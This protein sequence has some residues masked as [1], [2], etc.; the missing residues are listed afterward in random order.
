MGAR[1]LRPLFGT[2][3][4]LLM[5]AARAT[6]HPA[7]FTYLDIRVEDR[8]LEISLIAHAF[9]VAHD[10]GLTLPEQL[11]QDA[12][13]NE[14]GAQFAL[15]L[16]ERI[17]LSV[18]GRPL[19]L[20]PWQVAEALPERQSIRLTTRV[21]VSSPPGVVTLEAHI[22]PY[23]TA[24]QTFVN[25]YDRGAISSQSIL[26]AFETATNYYAGT[27]AG[28]W[29]AVR[30]ALP[31]AFW[32]ILIGLEHIAIIVGLLLLGGSLRRT[33]TLALVFTVGHLLTS[34][35][36][37][38][39]IVSLPERLIDPALALAVV[40]LGA[41]NLMAAGGRDV[42]IWMALVIGGIHGFGFA[43]LL[44]FLGLSRPALVWSIGAVNLGVG[45]ASVLLALIVSVAIRA[46]QHRGPRFTRL[47][48]VVGSVL[49][50]TLGVAWFAQ[51][52]FFPAFTAFPI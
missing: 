36:A 24:H 47:A 6:A 52:V 23:D 13:L 49:V 17:R 34:A 29:A 15:L 41:D 19:T 28:G 9:D 30:L 11:M 25:F 3:L 12:I 44:R 51:R 16:P 40:Y 18:D 35:L 45:A 31:Q 8:A 20:A 27:T 7:P 5:C 38:A 48:I 43:A 50:M 37:A 39:S 4:A 2:V 10:T 1:M 46:V 32:H 21:D 14:R 22:F 26:D 42:R 33:V